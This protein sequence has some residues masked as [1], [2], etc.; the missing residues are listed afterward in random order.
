MAVA[1]NWTEIMDRINSGEMPPKKQPRP[2]P[3]EIAR[4]ATGSA[5]QL[6][7][8]ESARQ[9]TSGEKVSFRRLS[10]EE[11]RNTIRDLL[12]V[13]YDASDPRACPKTRTGRAS[14]GSALC[15]RFRRRTWRNIWRRPKP[16]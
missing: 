5:G 2:D 13:T 14:S 1:G 11:Y 8:A 4:V 3:A 16:F 12:G 9:A 7:E 15:S 6:T 10:R